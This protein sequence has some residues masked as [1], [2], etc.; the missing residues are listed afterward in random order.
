MSAT[1]KRKRTSAVTS[2]AT[3]DH[4]FEMMPVWDADSP[5][6]SSSS[7]GGKRGRPTTIPSGSDLNVSS[8][9][10]E[11]AL[12]VRNKYLGVKVLRD[13][14]NVP[15]GPFEAKVMDVW[16]N[17]Q[18]GQM[19]FHLGYR[20][21]DR[22]YITWRDMNKLMISTAKIQRQRQLQRT[23]QH[24]HDADSKRST[25]QSKVIS[26]LSP[27]AQNTKAPRASSSTPPGMKRT[28]PL[29][30]NTRPTP[31]EP[32]TE[33]RIPSSSSSVGTERHAVGVGEFERKKGTDVAAA[34]TQNHVQNH[35]KPL[36]I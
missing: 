3:S 24:N 33:K 26:H 32:Q 7:R 22:E 34:A 11:A 2:Q 9:R 16:G 31:R 29:K 18:T 10:R 20:D 13:F 15:G 4:W 27:R 8:A 21:G 19:L 25:P 14:D 12:W 6:A 35:F 23:Q 30:P 1:G 36:A 17:A 28:P 5:G